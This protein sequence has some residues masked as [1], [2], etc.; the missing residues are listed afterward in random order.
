M[1]AERSPARLHPVLHGSCPQ[2]A[3]EALGVQIVQDTLV[4]KELLH[5]QLSNA[6]FL[7]SEAA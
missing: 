5:L 7:T 4:C 1:R 6:V 3:G 2:E